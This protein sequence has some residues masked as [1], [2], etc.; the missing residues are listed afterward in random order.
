[1]WVEG[2]EI[3]LSFLNDLHRQAAVAPDLH[4]KKFYRLLLPIGILPQIFQHNPKAFPQAG[5]LL[6]GHS[7]H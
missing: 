5:N 4:D 3:Y 6:R 2:H 7:L 1:M